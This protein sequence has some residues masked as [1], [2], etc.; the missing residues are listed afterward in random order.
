MAEKNFPEAI[1][2]TKGTEGEKEVL[3]IE[4]RI[5]GNKEIRTLMKADKNSVQKVPEDEVVK[6]EVL[7]VYMKL[8]K[9]YIFTGVAA[10]MA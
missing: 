2:A 7:P 5:E 4:K 3:F 6:E 1:S 8:L 9:T 10:Q